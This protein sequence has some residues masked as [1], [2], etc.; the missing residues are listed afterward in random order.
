MPVKHIPYTRDTVEGHAVL[1]NI[2]RTQRVLHY[3]ENNEVYSRI[4]RE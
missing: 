4:K 2:I 3:R 1:D